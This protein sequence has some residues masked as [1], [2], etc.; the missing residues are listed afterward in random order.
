MKFACESSV[1]VFENEF[2]SDMMKTEQNLSRSTEILGFSQKKKTRKKYFKV[3]DSSIELF[4]FITFLI[5]ECCGR[6]KMN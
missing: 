4:M 3:N 6:K 5:C 2:V 1:R